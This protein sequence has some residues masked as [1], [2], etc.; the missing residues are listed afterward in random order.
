MP[1]YLPIIR[2][3]G[4]QCWHQSGGDRAKAVELFTKMQP[5]AAASMDR[6]SDNL[7]R[8][9]VEWAPR[10]SFYRKKGSGGRRTITNEKELLDCCKALKRARRIG[11]V[12]R[13]YKSIMEAASYEKVISSTARKYAVTVAHLLRAMHRHDAHLVRGKEKVRRYLDDKHRASRRSTA[14]HMLK[15]SR[16]YFK[17]VFWLDAKHLYV[18]PPTDRVWCDASELGSLFVEDPAARPKPVC[19]HYY[20]VVNWFVGAVDLMWVTGTTGLKS[21]YKVSQPCAHTCCASL[22]YIQGGS[23]KCSWAPPLAQYWMNFSTAD[24]QLCLCR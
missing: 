4:A 1:S 12:W 17:R 2:K 10:D 19:L 13:H 8:W 11:G 16:E 6:P 9:G 15:L 23:Q 24:C 18:V 22:M 5:E 21:R 20:A 3:D 7:K 14:R